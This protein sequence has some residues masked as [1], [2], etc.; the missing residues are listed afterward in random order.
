MNN[1]IRALR[2]EKAQLDAQL[3]AGGLIPTSLSDG[4]QQAIQ[5]YREAQG[6]TRT[7]KEELIHNLGGALETVHEGLTTMFTDIMSGS[8]TVL[9]A[10]GDF[11][12]GMI[13]YMIQLAARAL[14]TQVFNMLLNVAAAWAGSGTGSSGASG[15]N[16]D[17]S[18]GTGF[19]SVGPGGAFGFTGMTNI[20]GVPYDGRGR[21][22]LLGGGRVMNGSSQK[23]SVNARIARDEWVVQ[24]PAVRSVGHEFMANLNAHGAAALDALRSA[25]IIQAPH[26]EVA[27]YVTQPNIPRQLGK[28]DIL[29]AVH[30]D[31]LQGGETSKLVKHVVNN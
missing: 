2:E 17:I 11:V 25:P 13:Q 16:L 4:L 15:F 9:Q 1:E 14:A 18:G 30:E 5:S 22:Q 7:F 10:F 28:N 29:V 19:N 21:A 12:Q 23:D 26:Q 8:K 20:G 27:V 3:S 24:G 31:L 6:L